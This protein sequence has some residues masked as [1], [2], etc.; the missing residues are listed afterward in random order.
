[1]S[2]EESRLQTSDAPPN[3]QAEERTEITSGLYPVDAQEVNVPVMLDNGAV[4]THVWKKPT[5][6]NHLDREEAMKR[7]SKGISRTE[8]ISERSEPQANAEFYNAVILRAE[9]KYKK[10][11]DG[12]EREIKEEFSQAHCL[13]LGVE[14]KHKAVSE[15]YQSTFEVEPED[16]SPFAQLFDRGGTMKI[17]E[18]FGNFVIRYILKVPTNS[19]RTEFGQSVQ[20]KEKFEKKNRRSLITTVNLKT[21]VKLFT[22]NFEAIEGAMC[23]GM[24]FTP[25]LK[26]KFLENIDPLK[27]YLAFDC[28]CG[29]F[30]Q[31][32]D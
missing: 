5:L 4:I 27:M 30:D 7:V 24:P 10:V 9:G 32:R 19:Q 29:S 6:E 20:V 3:G 2:T 18:E 11:V 26:K 1:M 17:R 12:E 23:G 21:G 16:D 28:A 15:A 13:T 31:A 22:Q 14:A 8:F 25:E